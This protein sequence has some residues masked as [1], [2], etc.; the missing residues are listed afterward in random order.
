MSLYLLSHWQHG[1]RQ[2]P[3]LLVSASLRTTT[4]S[5]LVGGPIREIPN[6]SLQ[7]LWGFQVGLLIWTNVS[8]LSRS[9]SI[10]RPLANAWVACPVVAPLGI[11]RKRHIMKHI[12]Q[13]VVRMHVKPNCNILNYYWHSALPLISLRYGRV[14]WPDFYEFW[15][16]CLE[17]WKEKSL[18]LLKFCYGIFDAKKVACPN[19]KSGSFIE[20]KHV[21]SKPAQ[22]NNFMTHRIM[23][24]TQVSSGV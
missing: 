4:A 3:V 22:L 14:R 18:L 10:S 1:L 6:V 2:T 13:P 23:I 9:P 12:T 24:C 16:C 21:F 15:K 8:H 19:F 5:Q 17:G 7:C 11:A 20:C